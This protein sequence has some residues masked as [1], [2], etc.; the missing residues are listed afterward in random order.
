M[1]VSADSAFGAYEEAGAPPAEIEGAKQYLRDR[2][3]EFLSMGPRIIDLQHRAALVAG[4]ARER[5]DLEGEAAAKQEIRNLGE[6]NKAHGWAVDTYQLE[7]VGARLGLGAFP[8]VAGALAFSALAGVVVWAFRS[9]EYSERKLDL[10]EAGVLTPAQAARL[11]PGPT[12]AAVL[13]GIGDLATLALWAAGLWIV[14]QVF[15]A[16]APKRKRSS[17]RRGNP[18]LEVWRQNPPGGWGE[19]HDLTYRHADDDEDYIHA[20]GPDVE[21]QGLS[22]GSVLLTHAG[23]AP[24]WDDFEV[25]E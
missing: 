17:A 21:L 25:D 16:Y 23:G 11:D 22:D 19:V 18:P 2:W 15:Q 14:F 12:P 4:A 20:F 5:G 1:Y 13:G 7:N 9:F 24:L 10:I 8:I 6:L 3:A